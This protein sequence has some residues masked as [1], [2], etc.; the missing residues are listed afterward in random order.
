MYA[1]PTVVYP[2]ILETY[3]EQYHQQLLLNTANSSSN[4]TN[5]NNSFL[6]NFPNNSP[7]F[8]STNDNNNRLIN[9]NASL[10]TSNINYEPT[11]TNGYSNST[12]IL[13]GN[14]SMNHN[15]NTLSSQLLN[16]N[17][18]QLTDNNN[19]N[20]NPW[21]GRNISPLTNPNTINNDVNIYTPLS[22][23]ST[24][25]SLNKNFSASDNTLSS[26]GNEK[27][28]LSVSTLSDSPVANENEAAM[29]A[30]RHALANHRNGFPSNITM[31]SQPPLPTNAPPPLPTGNYTYPNTNNNSLPTNSE[32]H[33]AYASILMSTPIDN[34][35]RG[36]RTNNTVV[37][38]PS[39]SNTTIPASL[40]PNNYNPN[41]NI[42]IPNSPNNN[43][44]PPSPPRNFVSGTLSL[45]SLPIPSNGYN[46]IDFRNGKNEQ[47]RNFSNNNKLIVITF[48]V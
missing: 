46:S 41:R 23:S 2:R 26:F 31:I 30:A 7:L 40:L 1:N 18:H 27:N 11:L 10:L 12:T 45:V 16:I 36:H 39:S 34:L 43:N 15:H 44:L 47:F 25:S 17:T 22:T 5:T 9:S 8:T 4:P 35:L 24:T 13:P 42:N 28:V 19:N 29:L 6:A 37:S 33:P 32:Y 20:N 38:N 3:N 14:N 21:I 48:Y